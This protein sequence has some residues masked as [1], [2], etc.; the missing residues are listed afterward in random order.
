VKISP[1][2]N[3]YVQAHPQAWEE[4]PDDAPLFDGIYGLDLHL[5]VGI[6]FVP[7]VSHL[8]P[9]WSGDLMPAEQIIR[10]AD[11][12][13]LFTALTTVYTVTPNA[14]LAGTDDTFT[15]LAPEIPDE[16]RRAVFYVTA[17]EFGRYTADIAT[18]S[19]FVGGL[20]TFVRVDQLRDYE[21]IRFVERRIVE[22]PLLQPEDAWWLGRAATPGR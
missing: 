1:S 16:L 20:R 6:A 9:P 8:A 5:N 17:D 21:V 2:A 3:Y 13:R 11:Q 4:D 15:W 12:A 22:S 7:E 14:R 10:T 18:L 19:E